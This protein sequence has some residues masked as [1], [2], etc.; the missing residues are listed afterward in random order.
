MRPHFPAEKETLVGQVTHSGAAK[1]T[2]G[3][4]HL[5]ADFKLLVV[6]HKALPG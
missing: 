4:A 1:K 2:I 6:P 5:V 3:G